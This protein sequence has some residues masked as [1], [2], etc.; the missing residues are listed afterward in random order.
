MRFFR[1][2][3]YHFSQGLTG[4]VRNGVMTVASILIL[5]SCMVILGTFYLVIRNIDENFNNMKNLNVIEVRIPAT[6]SED[7]I[8]EVRAGLQTICDDTAIIPGDPVF[9]SK[10]EHLQK[11]KELYGDQE[12]SE[13]FNEDLNPLR[14]SFQLTFTNFSDITE[15]VRIVSRIESITLSGG[16][17]AVAPSNIKSCIEVYRNVMSVKRTL[18]TVGLWL[19][20]ILLIISLF[21][22]INT[23]KLGIFARRN[24][25]MF[26]R[27]C[28][29]TK[30]FI[31]MPFL[32]E[33]ILIGLF[34][35]AASVGI[36]FL[37][38][39]YALSGLVRSS[40]SVI[41]GTGIALSPFS[42]HIPILIALFAVIGLFAGI[43]A[44]SI[45]LKKYLKA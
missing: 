14:P 35:A 13:F 15:V 33:G 32:F 36:E 41:S 9:I 5:V 11:F 21:V 17:T 12:W 34:S 6:Y 8:E 18:S 31:R 7:Q 10:E 27:Y 44:S 40:T 24:E 1:S 30:R 2:L 4:I 43:I 28:G 25:I 3:R 22:I 38:Y 29:A 19:M 16:A 26:M 39:T 37:L 20:G 45:S 42:G 23:I